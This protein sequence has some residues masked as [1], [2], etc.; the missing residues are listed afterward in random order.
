MLFMKNRVIACSLVVAFLLC[1]C[2]GKQEL[3]KN[4]N[5][6]S[7]DKSLVDLI[8]KNANRLFSLINQ[9]LDLRKIETNTLKL[10]S[11]SRFVFFIKK[12]KKNYNFCL[13]WYFLLYTFRFIVYINPW[14]CPGVSYLFSSSN[15]GNGVINRAPRL[16]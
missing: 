2:S 16:L 4:S 6:T 3:L 7:S 13:F 15:R 11:K 9:L 1:S 8:Q 12:Q 14:S 10:K 5:L